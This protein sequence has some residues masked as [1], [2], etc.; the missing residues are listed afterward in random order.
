[1][2]RSHSILVLFAAV[3][4]ASAANGQTADLTV[5]KT[6]PE[7]VSAGETID[8]SIFV[9]NGGP[10]AAQNVTV[11]DTLPFG[12]TFVALNASTTLF[13]CTTPSVGSAGTI[14]CTAASFEDEAET[15]F[16]ISV[17]TS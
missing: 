5:S 3:L 6:G 1:M 7:A 15:S 13:T 10:S 9:F 17:K 8:Y 11:T 4:F 2:R 12:T 16:T 14:T